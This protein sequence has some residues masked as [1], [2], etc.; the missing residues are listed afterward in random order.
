M[1]TT[2]ADRVALFG[3]DRQKPV[4]HG[5]RVG[6][7]ESAVQQAGGCVTYLDQP[8]TEP[9]VART[10]VPIVAADVGAPALLV[11]EN[12]DPSL[13][14]ITGVLLDGERAASPR[15]PAGKETVGSL[16]IEARRELSLRCGKSSVV[17]SSDG[18]VTIRG[19]RILSRARETNKV[20]GAT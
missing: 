7:L 6:T 13:P 17:L 2:R 11:F 5:V 10:T 16:E 4:I 8:G 12:G 14:I 19:V 20:K 1:E 3:Q 9:I 15:L 18:D